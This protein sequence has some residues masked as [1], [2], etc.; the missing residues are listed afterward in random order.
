METEIEKIREQQAERIELIRR[1]T[2][3][4]QIEFAQYLD[5]KPTSYSDIKRAKNGIS[6]NIMQK[7]ER[8][9]VNIDWLLTGRG[10]MKMPKSDRQTSRGMEMITP[11]STQPAES[12]NSYI[13]KLFKIIERRDEQIERLLTTNQE[14]DVLIS[15]ELRKI[16]EMFNKIGI[17]V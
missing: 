10:D 6:R 5:I 1:Q 11:Y 7:L 15:S 16:T 8:K 17:S 2:G 3:M 14:K 12:V 4:N 13:D 9:N